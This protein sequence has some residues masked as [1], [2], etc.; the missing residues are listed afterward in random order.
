LENDAYFVSF[1][2]YGGKETIG[3][4]KTWKDP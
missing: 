3:V 4:L 2:A 1:G